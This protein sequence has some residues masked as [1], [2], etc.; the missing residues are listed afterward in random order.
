M[1]IIIKTQDFFSVG[2]SQCS[3]V[4]LTSDLTDKSTARFHH[5]RMIA[6]FKPI[7]WGQTFLVFLN[8]VSAEC[9]C[10]VVHRHKEERAHYNSPCSLHWLPVY[11]RALICF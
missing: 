9:C 6:K 8:T 3:T 5:I 1:I 4:E 10:Q 11:F 7:H 2:L